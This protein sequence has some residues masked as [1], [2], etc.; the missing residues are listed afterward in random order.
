MPWVEGGGGGSCGGFVWVYYGGVC[1]R[2]L[3]EC[4]CTCTVGVVCLLCIMFVCVFAVGVSLCAFMCTALLREGVY[5]G[6]FVYAARV[7][8]CVCVCVYL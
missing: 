2:G 8:V 5:Y 1:V 3:R 6:G 4:V 7:C